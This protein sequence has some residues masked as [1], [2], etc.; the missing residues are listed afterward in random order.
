M[1]IGATP[2][3]EYHEVDIPIEPGSRLVLYT[4][5]LVE[6][7]GRIDRHRNRAIGRTPGSRFLSGRR[8]GGQDHRCSCVRRPPGRRR[9]RCRCGR[10]GQGVATYPRLARRAA[11]AWSHEGRAESLLE[12]IRAEEDEIFDILIAANEACSN[13]IEHPVESASGEQVVNL[14]AELVGGDVTDRHSGF[15]PL[16]ASGAEGGQ[17]ARS[18]VHGSTDGRGRSGTNARRNNSPSPPPATGRGSR[19]TDLAELE[20]VSVDGVSVARLSG[21]IDLSNAESIGDAV[22]PLFDR[23]G[24]GVVIDL[25]S[26]DYLDSAGVRLLFQVVQSGDRVGGSLR[27]VIPAASNIRRI[28]DLADIQHAIQLDESE[29]AAI[30]AIRA[31]LE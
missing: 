18:R 28:I 30:T 1:P 16:E 10:G 26:V 19:V 7:A 31:E 21:E 17:E 15:R 27:V 3:A 2:D 12:S 20:V 14:D 23:P 22:V 5:G 24:V 11:V 13:S 9:S 6:E 8:G 4:D 25:T 29:L